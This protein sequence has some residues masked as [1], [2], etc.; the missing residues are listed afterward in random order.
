MFKRVRNMFNRQSANESEKHSKQ[1][2]ASEYLHV[3]GADAEQVE[4]K[5][6]N[7]TEDFKKMKA[8]SNLTEL[9]QVLLNGTLEQE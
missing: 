6:E 2:G 4:R 3:E 8:H 7:Y 9:D 1:K 5:K